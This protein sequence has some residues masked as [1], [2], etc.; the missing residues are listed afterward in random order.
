MELSAEMA[1]LAK[2]KLRDTKRKQAQKKYRQLLKTK[3][4][5][6]LTEDDEI[7]K[8]ASLAKKKLYMAEYQKKRKETALK[9]KADAKST[10]DLIVQKYKSGE[11]SN[12]S[13]DELINML[14]KSMDF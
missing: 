4:A 11:L 14:V 8:Q 1:E 7:K 2:Y 9:K 5:K 13:K 3:Q 6:P 10:K 12:L